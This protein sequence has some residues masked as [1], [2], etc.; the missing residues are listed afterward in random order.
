MTS[1]KYIFIILLFLFAFA[2]EASA[3]KDSL[4]ILLEQSG[5]E[6][7]QGTFIIRKNKTINKPYSVRTLDP[8]PSYDH[9]PF[10]FHCRMYCGFR[11]R[12][13]V[14]FDVLH[15]GYQYYDYTFIEVGYARKRKS[16]FADTRGFQLEFNAE[17]D[18]IGITGFLQE[19]LIKHNQ[20]EVLTL[21]LAGTAYNSGSRFEFCLRHSIGLSI[22]RGRWSNLQLNLGYN[23]FPGTPIIHGLNREY[24]SLRYRFSFYS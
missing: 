3:Q 4:D 13:R 24:A 15:V 12:D 19:P 7:P 1:E 8:M 17:K 9:Y 2:P 20:L 10:L 5:R 14:K 6:A 11:G 21:N 16:K 23:F 18:I 22:P